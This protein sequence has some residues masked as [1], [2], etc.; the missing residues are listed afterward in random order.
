MNV[1]VLGVLSMLLSRLRLALFRV[2]GGIVSSPLVLRAVVHVRKSATNLP[3][4]FVKS[5]SS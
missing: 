1:L 3:V 5:S 4:H 2:V